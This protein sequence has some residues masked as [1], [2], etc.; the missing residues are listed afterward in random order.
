MGSIDQSKMENG[1]KDL[2][3]Q[4][5]WTKWTTQLGLFITWG[6]KLDQIYEIRVLQLK[7]GVTLWQKTWAD[8]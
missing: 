6:N 8:K 1:P 5:D 2:G 4:I 7:P 3:R